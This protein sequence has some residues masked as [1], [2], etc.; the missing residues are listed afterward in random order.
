MENTAPQ[1]SNPLSKYFRQPAIYL[2]LPSN[3]KYWP[4]GSLDLPI[5]EEIPVYPMTARDEI[6]LRTPDAL[7]SGT[8]VVEVIKSCCPNIVDPWSMPSIDVDTT[9]IAIRV[10]SYGHDMDLD[11]N[12]PH[13]QAENNFALDLRLLLANTPKPDYTNPVTTHNLKIIL[14]PQKFTEINKTNTVN[15]EETR[16]VKAIGDQAIP[17]EERIRQVNESMKRLL[18]LSIEA[19]TNSTESIEVDGQSVTDR[20]FIKDFYN[21]A[22]G[23]II[24]DVQKR[25]VEL[26]NE[27]DLVPQRTNC[28]SCTKEFV[29]PIEFDY[30]NFF[31]TGS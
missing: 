15:F 3:G 24:R 13:C 16:L 28:T 2:K 18:D 19:A 7:M 30:S 29:V 1:L 20:K 23:S 12:C 27:A 9:L 31:A 10:A 14:K 6:T 5:N 11:V 4:P 17:E 8:G 22:E 25:L 21:N 26:S